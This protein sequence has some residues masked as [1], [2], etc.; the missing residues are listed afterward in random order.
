M[1][2]TINGLK[3]NSIEALENR[4]FDKLTQYLKNLY[5]IKVVGTYSEN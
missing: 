4:E 3:I 5:K 1:I 2:I